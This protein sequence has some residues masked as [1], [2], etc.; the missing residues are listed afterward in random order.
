MKKSVCRAKTQLQKR[1]QDGARFC[2]VTD[3]A[4]SPCAVGG[5]RAGICGG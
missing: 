3:K 5:V 2:C 1:A 4:P